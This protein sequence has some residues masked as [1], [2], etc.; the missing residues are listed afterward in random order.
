MQLEI[1]WDI[2]EESTTKKFE[3]NYT[4]YVFYDSNTG[5]IRRITPDL[6]DD[7]NPYVE[8]HFDEVKNIING[9]ESWKDYKVI[10]SPDEKTFVLVKL[11]VVQETLE[12]ANDIIYQ[13]PCTVDTSVPLVFDTTN[14][15]TIVQDFTDVCWRVLINWKLAETLKGKNLYFDTVFEFYVTSYNDPNVLLKTL[16]VPIKNLV[17]NSYYI[18]PFD[19]LELDNTPISIYTRKQFYKYQ[20][21]RT[22][23]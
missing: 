12:T 22:K 20:Y 17:E 1:V 15:L 10:F 16:R 7:I 23:L 2:P 18:F 5:A 19:R 6:E 13:V 14:D 4:R 21:I 11:E 3:P 9:I 8:V